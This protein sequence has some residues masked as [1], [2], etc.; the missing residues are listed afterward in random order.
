MEEKHKKLT[1]TPYEYADLAYRYVQ[2]VQSGDS[3]VD[4]G[5]GELYT[6]VEMHTLSLIED[7]PGITASDIAER[8]YRTKGAVSQILNK[9]EEKG[10]I[11]REKDPQNA[12]R[13]CLYVTPIGL[14]LSQKHK[15]YDEKHM[16]DVLEDWISLFGYDAV[17]KFY[18][19]M[20]YYI[21]SYPSLLANSMK[22]QSET[23]VNKKKK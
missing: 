2:C 20:N 10:L 1:K 8:N 7:Y 4:Y 12:R 17:E 16:G 15:E 19:I 18:A 3:A 22:E 9:L 21:E 13:V 14:D 6:Y 23:S 5:T 11:R